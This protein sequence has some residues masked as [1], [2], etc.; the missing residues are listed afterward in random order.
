LKTS[1]NIVLIVSFGLL[2][3]QVAATLGSGQLFGFQ[4]RGQDVSLLTFAWIAF[5]TVL[6]TVLGSIYA[7]L[8]KQS[9]AGS[10][11]WRSAIEAM[12]SPRFGMS[13]LVTPIIVFV[14]FDQVDHKNAD[15]G[16]ALFCLQSG[17]FW[18]RTFDVVAGKA[19][20]S[21]GSA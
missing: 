12:K 3:Y 2:A 11:W 8:G 1:V 17:F 7:F 15:L 16:I 21:P 10:P 18:D 9:Q 19:A 20:P 6:G 4:Y 5:A 13:L 14:V